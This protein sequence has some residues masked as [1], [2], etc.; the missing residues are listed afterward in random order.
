MFLQKLIFRLPSKLEGLGV[1]S[2]TMSQTHRGSLW[3]ALVT[4]LSTMDSSSV[5]TGDTSS[6]RSSHICL[7]ISRNYVFQLWFLSVHTLLAPK[8]YCY[9]L[10]AEKGALYMLG[11]QRRAAQLR[12][13]LVT[14]ENFSRNLGDVGLKVK[15]KKPLLL[16]RVTPF[17]LP[18][19]SMVMNCHQPPHILQGS[20]SSA[21][22]DP[23]HRVLKSPQGPFVMLCKLV[24]WTPVRSFSI[25]ISGSAAD[26]N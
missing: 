22:P 2:L 24:V 26:H 13:L 8:A 15:K 25:A 12:R 18:A 1:L 16:P 17:A 10:L 14:N 20:S 21:F 4:C 9:S 23:P 19:L 6:C 3:A 5:G 11:V 7:F